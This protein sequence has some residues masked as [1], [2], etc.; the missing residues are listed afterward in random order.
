MTPRGI[1]NNNPGNIRKS[2][3]RWQGEADSQPDPDFVTFE[4]PTY[5]LRALMVTLLTYER[6]YQLNSVAGI[7]NRYAPAVEND[8][9]S[10]V[11]AV[12]DHMNV[13]PFK[14]L[15]PFDAETLTGFAEAITLHENG[16]CPDPTLPNWYPE[17]TYQKAAEM[18]LGLQP[19]T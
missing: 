1:R 16:K 6:H 11:A 2:R 3:D 4:S 15:S 14:S 8:V 12:S 7:I 9:Y 19:Q 10:Y 18:A 5:G 17:E 13:N